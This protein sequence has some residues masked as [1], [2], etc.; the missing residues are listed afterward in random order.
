MKTKLISNI[1]ETL[2]R[3]G[4]E[5]KDADLQDMT[6][7]KKIFFTKSDVAILKNMMLDFKNAKNKTLYVFNCQEMLDFQDLYNAVLNVADRILDNVN[8][9]SNFRVLHSLLNKIKTLYDQRHLREMSTVFSLSTKRLLKNLN[10]LMQESILKI[11][12]V[13]KHDIRFFLNKFNELLALYNAQ[14]NILKK[15][16]LGITDNQLNI[17]RVEFEINNFRNL[18]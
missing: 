8:V 7:L 6:M 3:V 9:E 4:D 11:F 13:E 18:D 17:I 12:Y 15:L 1:V 5:I 2:D 14:N 10:D 16:L